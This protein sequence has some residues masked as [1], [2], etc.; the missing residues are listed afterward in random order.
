MATTNWRAVCQWCG[1]MGNGGSSPNE[2]PPPGKPEV[3][4][5][6]PSH[7]SGKKDANHAPKWEKR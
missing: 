6:C 2:N 1:K 5:K 7:P 4:G 3:P